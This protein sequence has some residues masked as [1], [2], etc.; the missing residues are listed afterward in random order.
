[1]RTLTISQLLYI[2]ILILM[3]IISV[4]K[5]AGFDRD[6]E[7]Y[8]ERFY[9]LQPCSPID[10]IKEDHV[11][12]RFDMLF[13]YIASIVRFNQIEFFGILLFFSGIP[14]LIK[15]YVFRIVSDSP[16]KLILLYSSTS[17]LLHE[18]TQIRVAAASTFCWLALLAY[19]EW[20]KHAVSMI[21]ILLA[22]LFHPIALIFFPCIIF[23]TRNFS[24]KILLFSIAIGFLSSF[25]LPYISN[26]FFL[27]M[28]GAF[29]KIQVYQELMRDGIH[30]GYNRYNLYYICLIIILILMILY[31]DRISNFKYEKIKYFNVGLNFFVA[32]VVTFYSF[33]FFPVGA[34][35]LSEFLLSFGWVAVVFFFDCVKP[36]IFSNLIFGFLIFCFFI[37]NVVYNGLIIM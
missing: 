2:Y 29:Y 20:K 8:I 30:S 1:M 31:R 16:L 17:F 7:N 22:A 15:G 35:R 28:G 4:F 37:L 18:I 6:Y 21:L 10:C 24:S 27:Y 13:D 11:R 9:Y 26:I 19:L 36:L 34:F 12:I 5:P 25:F 23:L 3:F 33:S 32:A 14:L